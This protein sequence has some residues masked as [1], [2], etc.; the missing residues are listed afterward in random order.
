GLVIDVRT[1]VIDIC[2]AGIRGLVA[3][4]NAGTERDRPIETEIR[5]N[6]SHGG[7][8]LPPV[9][10]KRGGVRLSRPPVPVAVE[11]PAGAK[12]RVPVT[13]RDEIL[14]KLREVGVVSAGR[15]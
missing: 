9:R 5:R 3:A 11:L 10:T 6:R 2:V 13:V 7:H 4:R 1:Y 14:S 8:D 12:N 15:A